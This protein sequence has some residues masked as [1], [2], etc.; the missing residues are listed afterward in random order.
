MTY[1]YGI[2]LNPGPGDFL[3]FI[4]GFCEIIERSKRPGIV[5]C[6]IDAW[7]RCGKVLL[8]IIPKVEINL[9]G[10][11]Y[12]MNEELK[13]MSRTDIWHCYEIDF[14]NPVTKQLPIEVTY[15]TEHLYR[16]IDRRTSEDYMVGKLSRHISLP[17]MNK[18]GRG[19]LFIRDMKIRP[20]RNMNAVILKAI[21]KIA[22]EKDILLDIV[23]CRQN[24]EWKYLT[25]GK[26]IR[27]LYLEGYPDYY[28]QMMEYSQYE[29]AIGMNSG[30][31]D[32]AIASGV[33]SVRVG[34]FH[35]Y[36]P[37]LGRN[38]NSFLSTSVTVNI[39]SLS[40]TDISNIG[41]VE[42]R[43]AFDLLESENNNTILWI[44]VEN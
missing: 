24:K 44:E 17:K 3:R 9:Y 42:L 5:L 16:Y 22:K 14:I 27:E 20:E 32:L 1:I 25:D 8:Q 41:E 43:R 10:S 38:Y 35:Q 11:F 19:L 29:F 4:H 7:E 36:I 12:T 37:W 6:T 31:L 2:L 33:P 30:G 40:E 13:R 39:E 21:L 28:T 34:E 23:G 15:G 26:T 18:N